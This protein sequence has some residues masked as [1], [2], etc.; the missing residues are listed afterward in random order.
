M[1]LNMYEGLILDSSRLDK[2]VI[3]T[4][5]VTKLDTSGG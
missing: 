3:L 5:K 4:P 1:L 2:L